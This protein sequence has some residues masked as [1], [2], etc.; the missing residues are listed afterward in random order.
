[1]TQ[2]LAEILAELKRRQNDR[3]SFLDPKFEKQFAATQDRSFLKAV[4]CTRR[5]G[6]TTGEASEQ[7]EEAVNLTP[8]SKHL[9]MALSLESARNIVW[10]TFLEKLDTHKIMH[11]SHR[12]T[13]EIFLPEGSYIKLFGLDSSYKDMRKVLGGKYKT[14]KIDEA[15]SITQDLKKIC[16][17]MIMPALTDLN[18]RLTLLGTAEN[19]PRTFFESV[20]SGKEKGWSVHKWTTLD[21]PYMREEWQKHL[22]W[23][24]ENNP[25]FKKTSEYR[26]H[27]LNEWCADDTKRIVKLSDKNFISPRDLPGYHFV[28]GVDLGY[29]DSS[30]FTVMA[31]H[32]K[33]PYAYVVSSFKKRE[34]DITGVANVIRGRM[35]VYPISKI[36]VDGANKQ[37]VEEMRNRHRLPLEVAEKQDK[38]TFLKM[39]ADDVSQER[40]KLF[41]GE[42]NDL[43]DEWESLQWEDEYQDTED[44]RCE[45]HASDATLYA[46]RYVRNYLF[47]PEEKAPDFGT[48][49]YMKK[50][51]KEL[52]KRRRGNDD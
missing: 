31:Y 34:L 25:A 3:P 26:T 20:T 21:N 35:T 46:W 41:Q 2:R 17:Q 29:N 8:G 32:L 15:G 48:D 38:A 47:R 28:L 19:I 43:S 5:A 50:Y 45:N 51:A 22:N 39:L 49:E 23:I 6:K 18:G 37:G 16:Y 33:D 27:Y 12:Q 10:D 42:T 11:K 24:E 7:L 40:V 4:Q 52:E 9:Y 44:P 30:S 1:L 13:G 14:V 36:I